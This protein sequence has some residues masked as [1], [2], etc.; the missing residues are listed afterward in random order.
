MLDNVILPYYVK[1][2]YNLNMNMFRLSKITIL[3]FTN[4]ICKKKKEILS[5]YKVINELKS[6]TFKLV[7]L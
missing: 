5:M 3:N 7:N 1:K 4:L 6:M 2:K